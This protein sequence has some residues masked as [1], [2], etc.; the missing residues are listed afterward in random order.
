MLS[1]RGAEG[2]PCALPCSGHIFPKP[3]HITQMLLLRV[4]WAT[5][6]PKALWEDGGSLLQE[7]GFSRGNLLQGRTSRL[8]PDQEDF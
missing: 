4:S 3:F 1:T 7:L 5:Q 8:W 2:R 6:E